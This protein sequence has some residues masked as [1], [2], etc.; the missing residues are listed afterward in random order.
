MENEKDSK[1]EYLRKAF[2]AIF[3]FGG[4]AALGAWLI[5]PAA[6]AMN[7]PPQQPAVSNVSH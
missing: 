2:L 5:Q 7:P 6:A 3:V 4:L 1:L